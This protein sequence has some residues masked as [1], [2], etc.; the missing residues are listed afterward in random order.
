MLVNDQQQVLSGLYSE[1]FFCAIRSKK[2][3]SLESPAFQNAKTARFFASLKRGPV[4]CGG[5]WKWSFTVWEWSTDRVDVLF[6]YIKDHIWGPVTLFFYVLFELW[7]HFLIALTRLYLLSQ[8]ARSDTRAEGRGLQALCRGVLR[9]WP[10]P[11]HPSVPLGKG[12]PWFALS[13]IQ[14]FRIWV[15]GQSSKSNFPGRL[16]LCLPSPKVIP[17]HLHGVWFCSF[18]AQESLISVGRNTDWESLHQAR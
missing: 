8:A 15:N 12:R 11:Q 4:H 13:R 1:P 10:I 16:G 5:Q 6:G 9:V 18:S 7:Y 14:L 2:I 3:N 17:G